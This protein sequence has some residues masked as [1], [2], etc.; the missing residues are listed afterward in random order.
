MD[1]RGFEGKGVFKKDASASLGSWA[2]VADPTR[3]TSA[4]V[5]RPTLSFFSGGAVTVRFE[6]S[7]TLSSEDDRLEATTEA[8][9]VLAAAGAGTLPADGIV[10]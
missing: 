2:D 6:T 7:W 8:S 4:F 1:H 10:A 3:R 9:S 5:G